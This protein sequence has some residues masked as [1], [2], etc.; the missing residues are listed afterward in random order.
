MSM[1]SR[2]RFDLDIMRSNSLELYDP[3]VTMLV[4]NVALRTYNNS[5]SAKSAMRLVTENRWPHPR[6]R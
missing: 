6:V 5:S 3:T 1:L 2:I 4:W